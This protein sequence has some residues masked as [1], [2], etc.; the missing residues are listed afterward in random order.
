MFTAAAT[1]LGN[2]FSG[3]T[4][5]WGFGISDLWSSSMGIVGSLAPFILLGLSIVMAPKIFRLI[6]SA[7]AGGGGKKG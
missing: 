5:D 7:S 2:I 1:P 6:R 3:I 4:T